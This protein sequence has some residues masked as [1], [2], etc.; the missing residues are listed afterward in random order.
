LPLEKQWLPPGSRI[1]PRDTQEEDM[2]RTSWTGHGCIDL[3]K[4][5]SP[6]SG[7]RSYCSV[8]QARPGQGHAGMCRIAVQI[9][10]GDTVHSIAA[11]A[12][13]A[14]CGDSQKRSPMAQSQPD[15]IQSSLLLL[16]KSVVTIARVSD[17]DFEFPREQSVSV[18]TCRC[19]FKLAKLIG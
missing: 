17:S 4:K 13:I 12:C 10:N 19:P 2:V 14:T 9:F 6:P 16:A 7:G 1:R 3:E 18:G 5:P 15:A 8:N 11:M